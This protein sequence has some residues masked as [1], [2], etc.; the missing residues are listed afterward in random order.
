MKEISNLLPSTP[1]YN[2]VWDVEQVLNHLKTYVPN[3]ETSVK[4]LSFKL[5]MLLALAATQQ[6][7]KE[8]VLYI[9]LRQKTNTFFLP[10][11]SLIYQNK[12]KDM[13]F[14]AFP[15]KQNLRQ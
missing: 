15:S 9:W 1:T 13:H 6:P 11:Q 2:F 7:W 14:Y 5:S 8:G 4:L 10:K 3:S 12:A